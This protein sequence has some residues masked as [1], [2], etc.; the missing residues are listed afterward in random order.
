MFSA[1]LA[2]KRSN[3]RAALSALY[4]REYGSPFISNGTTVVY[5]AGHSPSGNT[6]S[7]P[8]PSARTVSIENLPLPVLYES[9]CCSPS[10]M[11]GANAD[12]PFDQVPVNTSLGVIAIAA[13]SEPRILS[14]QRW[15]RQR[16]RAVAPPVRLRGPGQHPV[17]VS[18]RQKA[19]R[20]HAGHRQLVRLAICAVEAR[21]PQPLELCIARQRAP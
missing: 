13:P 19:H 10:S 6:E 21:P 4:A 14:H 16:H 9:R 15:H 7:V 12:Q 11:N 20:A 2:L 3:D 18:R 5:P 8:V 1:P 17:P